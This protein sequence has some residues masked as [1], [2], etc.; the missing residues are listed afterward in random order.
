MWKILQRRQYLKR[1]FK[2]NFSYKKMRINKK[3]ELTQGLVY[4]YNVST[5]KLNIQ[6]SNQRK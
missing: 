4:M 5:S 3:G 1:I 6:Q 2:A